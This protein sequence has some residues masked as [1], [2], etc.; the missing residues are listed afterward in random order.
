MDTIKQK[1]D[2]KTQLQKKCNA[3]HSVEDLI[4]ELYQATKESD[5][6]GIRS[7]AF[8]VR[9]KELLDIDIEDEEGEDLYI[10]TIMKQMQF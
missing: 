10:S 6:D 2:V 3:I 8:R 4:V 1:Q 5:V 7:K 9:A